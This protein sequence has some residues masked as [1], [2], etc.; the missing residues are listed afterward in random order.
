[1]G[2]P[3]SLLAA[4]PGMEFVDTGLYTGPEDAGGEGTLRLLAAMGC[5]A[6]LGLVGCDKPAQSVD[7]CVTPRLTAPTDPR[8]YAGQRELAH[9]CMKTAAY[10]IARDG[11]AVDLVADAVFRQ[12]AGKEADEI[13]ALKRTGPVYPYQIAQIHEGLVHLARISA[14]Q[15]RAKGCGLSPGERADSMLESKP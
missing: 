9:V 1:M 4:A 8:D 13:A 12:C 14:I 10:A 7:T 6:A 5:A 2:Q 3:F 11:R 15:A